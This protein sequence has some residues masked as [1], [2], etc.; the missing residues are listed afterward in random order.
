[1]LIDHHK[2]AQILAYITV[3]YINSSAKDK[4]S[5]IYLICW[6]KMV[7]IRHLR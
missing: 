5:L 3:T 6:A 4:L 7:F 1:M 2:S